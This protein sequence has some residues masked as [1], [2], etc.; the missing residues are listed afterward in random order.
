MKKKVLLK[1]PLL[2]RSGYGEHARFVL[3]SLRSR[4]DLYDVFIQPLQWGQTS[5]MNEANEERTWIDHTIE[6]TIAYIQHKGHFDLSL[7]VTIPNEWEKIAPVNIGVTAGIETTK[8]APQWIEKGDAMDKIIVVSNHSKKVYEDTVYIAQFNDT[9][10]QMEVKL[11]TPIE[12]VNYP[13]KKYNNVEKADIK[14]DYNFNF[15]TIAQSGPRKNIPNT[16]KW[17][18][19]EFYEEEV[20]LVLKSNI[21]KN[22]LMDREKLFA[23]IKQS[24][25]NL[26]KNSPSSTTRK[27]KVYLLHGDMSDEEIHSLYT[28]PQI[29]AFLSLSHGEG[30]GLP[31]Y[32]AAYSG[33]PVI[34]PGWSGHLDFLVD[35][36]KGISQFQNV[37]Y[38]IQPVPDGA[39]WEGVI[40]KESMW[41][42]PRE[43]SAK[44]NMRYC[45]ANVKKTNK[46]AKEL[47]S[48]LEVDFAEDKQYEKFIN[49]MGQ[50]D[51][52]DD[53]LD[54]IEE[55]V[56]SYE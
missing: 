52:A 32:E 8:V 54:E 3:R 33:L 34:A 35:K 39:V 38:D 22:C 47:A 55:I 10:Q 13:V 37:E 31:I 26:E 28:H 11:T 36:K 17:F 44:Q 53:W 15:L 14:L 2:T 45:Y 42:Y 51:N 30:F 27:C 56:Q 18:M 7:Q 21:A 4:P 46:T 43:H 29:K 19:E 41:A 49:A 25:A 24:I 6:K 48:R 16:I 20:G 12:A 9:G 40:V 1:G 23:E 50:Q 5:W